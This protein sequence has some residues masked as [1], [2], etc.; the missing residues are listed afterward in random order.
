MSIFNSLE[1]ILNDMENKIVDEDVII[2]K[3][4]K[5]ADADLK[6]LLLADKD[7]NVINEEIIKEGKKDPKAKV[8]NKP[9]PIFGDKSSKVTDDKDHFPINTKARARNVLAR[10]GA[11]KDNPPKWYKGTLSAFQ[12]AVK[13]A[14]KKAYPDIE[15]SKE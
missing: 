2:T 11:F 5:Q 1:K 3:D 15:I 14:V 8:R 12:K 13:S 7:K 4:D 9:E 6:N 10:A